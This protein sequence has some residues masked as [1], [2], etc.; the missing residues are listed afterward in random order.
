[1]SGVPRVTIGVPVYNGAETLE[2][3]LRS[4]QAQTFT[5]L[6][7]LVSDN[8]ST[9]ATPDVMARLA[10]EDPRIRYVRQDTN[11]GANGNYSFVAREARGEFLKWAS[12]SDWC[13]PT[14]VARCL[15]ALLA[16]PGAVLAAPRTR[17]FVGDPSDGQ[18]YEWDLALLAERPLDR[19]KDWLDRGRLN[20]A[21]NGLIRLDALRRTGL[22][23]PYMGADVVLMGHLALLG[24]FLLVEER[25][26]F[27]RM[28]VA[29]ST[30]LQDPAARLR[31]HYPVVTARTLLQ[32][33]KEQ[34]G[35]LRAGA[36]APL[37]PI[38]RMRVLGYLGRRFVW[39]REALLRD[40]LGALR[41]AAGPRQ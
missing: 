13:A 29:T 14:L 21:F 11:I 10:A 9:D 24:K 28:E 19:L 25:L 31:H 8:A 6:E 3:A 38:E 1:V 18:D 2:P 16:D 5:D 35:W 40:L 4:L 15:E 12:A 20:N 41:F 33:W 23:P 22:I 36:A 30:A 17:L 39:E 26:Y 37:P 27:R 7:I 34:F 32:V